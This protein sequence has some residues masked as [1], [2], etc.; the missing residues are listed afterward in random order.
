MVSCDF[1]AGCD[2]RALPDL[3]S[4][5]LPR[6]PDLLRAEPSGRLALAGVFRPAGALART[7]GVHR[8]GPAG[9]RRV[10]AVGLQAGVSPRFDLDDDSVAGVDSPVV[11]AFL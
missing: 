11:K 7:R 9:G 10:A 8:D 5:L 2:D 6:L 1:S 4:P 3:P